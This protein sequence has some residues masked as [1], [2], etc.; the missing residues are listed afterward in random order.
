M[1][2]TFSYSKEGTGEYDSVCKALLR[3]LKSYCLEVE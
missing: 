2:L 3:K 1:P